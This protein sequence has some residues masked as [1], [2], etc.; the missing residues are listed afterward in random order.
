MSTR[1]TKVQASAVAVL[2]ICS[3]TLLAVFLADAIRGNRMYARL[4][5]YVEVLKPRLA[6]DPRFADVKM[7]GSTALGIDVTGSV[8]T[9]EDL[10]S[11]QRIVQ[12]SR[13]P[14]RVVATVSVGS[15]AERSVSGAPKIAW[16]VNPP[17]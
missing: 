3:L 14:V 11:L 16:V 15:P 5:A 13:P 9:Q 1:W 10:M 6:S 8:R 7:V 12:E 4:S 17:E 2:A